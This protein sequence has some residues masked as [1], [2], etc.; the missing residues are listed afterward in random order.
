MSLSLPKLHTVDT[1]RLRAI[2]ER[3]QVWNHPMEHNGIT[4]AFTSESDDAFPR[5]MLR[6]YQEGAFKDCNR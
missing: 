4:S 2:S 3:S 6:V 1:R 5:I